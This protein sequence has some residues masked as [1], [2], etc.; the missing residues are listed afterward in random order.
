MEICIISKK[1][2]KVNS[3]FVKYHPAFSPAGIQ[4]LKVN[5]RNTRI[6]REICS[7]LTI[8]TPERHHW[9]HSGVL[10]AN[11]E[12]IP[13]LAF[14][15]CSSVSSVNFEHVI[16]GWVKIRFLTAPNKIRTEPKIC[17]YIIWDYVYSHKT[18][19]QCFN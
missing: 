6:I 13:H 15:S 3:G 17:R 8:K 19:R 10:I 4:L 14:P 5:N 7:K 9:R 2:Y 16:S 11:F 12:H 18:K 1:T